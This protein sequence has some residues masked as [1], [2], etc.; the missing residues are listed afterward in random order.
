MSTR[1]EKGPYPAIHASNRMP[2][3]VL[4]QAKDDPTDPVENSLVYYSALRKAG[5]PAKIHVYVTG[6]HAIGS[7]RTESPTTGWLQLVEAW[8]G[9]IGVIPRQV[10]ARRRTRG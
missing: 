10:R 9:T 6:G 8:L 4:F 2:P 5:V 3:T 1:F 7:R